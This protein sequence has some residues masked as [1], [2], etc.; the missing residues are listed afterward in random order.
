MQIAVLP[1]SEWKRI[2]AKFSSW[3]DPVPSRAVEE[4]RRKEAL[5]EQSRCSV[6][7]WENTIEGQRLKRLE[8]RKHREV[9]DEVTMGVNS[10][11]LFSMTFLPERACED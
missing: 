2:K 6:Q 8:A 10:L 1:F 4:R 11:A 3:Q 7:H 9:K 5:H